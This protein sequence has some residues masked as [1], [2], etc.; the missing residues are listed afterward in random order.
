MVY[1]AF[2]AGMLMFIAMQSILQDIMGKEEFLRRTEA[3]W[4]PWY[5]TVPIAVLLIFMAMSMLGK[6][7][8]EERAKGG[9]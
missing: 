9:D 8:R 7:G 6:S 5:V 3:M 4:I 2:W 1:R